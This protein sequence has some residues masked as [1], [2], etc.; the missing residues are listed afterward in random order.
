MYLLK[1]THNRWTC[2]VQTSI[3]QRPTVFPSPKGIKKQI[4]QA[5]CEICLIENLWIHMKQKLQLKLIKDTPL[6]CKETKVWKCYYL[7][8]MRYFCISRQPAVVSHLI[9]WLNY[10]LKIWVFMESTWTKC[11]CNFISNKVKISRVHLLFRFSPIVI[12]LGPLFSA[13]GTH[14]PVTFSNYCF[15]DYLFSPCSYKQ[16]ICI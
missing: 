7:N 14:I 4:K 15:S 5:W 3:V 1:N 13:L 12:L 6:K 2:A 9:L 8:G 10:V 11:T 16:V